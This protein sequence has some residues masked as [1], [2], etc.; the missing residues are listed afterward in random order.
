MREILKLLPQFYPMCEEQR[1]RFFPLP[2]YS[3]SNRDR[4]VLEIYGHSI[5][6]N[7]SKLLIEKKDNLALADVI[8]LDKIQKGQPINDADANRLK[9]HKLILD[10]LPSV[11]DSKQKENKVRNL[12]YAMLKKR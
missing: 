3:K 6:E 5:D 4:V 8:F 1:E 9:R 2:D 10:I 11:L 12:V 7:Y